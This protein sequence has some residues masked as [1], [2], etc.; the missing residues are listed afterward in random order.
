MWRS[1]RGDREGE[2]EVVE[3]KIEVLAERAKEKR[4]EVVKME[5]RNMEGNIKGR[6]RDEW[7]DDV[8]CYTRTQIYKLI[9]LQ[10]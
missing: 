6:R 7:E 3:K 5:G 9:F 2:K 1:W 10:L 4:E 8:L